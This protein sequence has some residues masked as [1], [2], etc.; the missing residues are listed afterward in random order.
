MGVLENAMKLANQD[1]DAEEEDGPE[2]GV[3]K[4][5]VRPVAQRAK[6]P[7]PSPE[8]P[9]APGQ[10]SKL[11]PKAQQQLDFLQTRRQQ[12]MR[13]ALRSK[14]MKDMQGAA[15]HLRHAK[16]LDPMISAA[17]GG[18]PVDITKVP[19]APVSEEDYSLAQSRSSPLSPRTSE[20]Y[21]QLMDHLRQQH[22]KCLGYSQQ[23]THMGNVAETTRIYPD[24][25]ANELVLTIVKGINL[26]APSGV[27]PND[28]DAKYKE[29]FKLNI[30]RTHRG[31]KRV[32]QTK[33][34]KFEVIHKGGLF[35]GDKVVGSA[36]LKLES[37]ETQCEIRQLIEVLDGRKPTGAPGGA[38][39][40]SGAA[41]GPQLHTVTERWLVLDPITEPPPK[42]TTGRRREQ[43]PPHKK[44]SVGSAP[45]SSPHN[46]H[47]KNSGVRP[48]PQ[49]KL[50]SFKLLS[51]DKERLDSK[52]TEYK[53]SRRDVPPD[54]VQ[55]HRELSHRLQW[56]SAQLERASPSLVSEY[57]RVLQRLVQGLGEG[58]K[59][60]SSQGNREAAKEALG[61]MR[62]VE[63][64]MENLRRRRTV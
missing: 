6:A 9:P 3:A 58:V 47:G 34:I 16:G 27:S 44:E 22:E 35:K 56:Q 53:R 63:S 19:S 59:K 20:Q 33:G 60:Y 10:G 51:Y 52:I 12:F 26:P 1:A 39:E 46:D 4:T 45:K 42:E 40:D 11:G 17:Q 48:P 38:G 61:R 15:L 54:L 14:Q 55:Q 57:E 43:G 49:Y 29:K 31:F 13:A 7:A 25:T 28:L 5:A 30:N 24:L 36:Q 32:V 41:G 8:T 21:A 37:L 23:F 62:L 18:L 50:H 64:E 2:E